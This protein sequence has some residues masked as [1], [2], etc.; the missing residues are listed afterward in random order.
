M[1]HL[2]ESEPLAAGLPAK[3]QRRS[4]L[5]RR[6]IVEETL[7]PGASVA[8]VAREHEVNANQVHYWRKL[9]QQ[10]LLD[11]NAS[12]AA[13][14]PVRLTDAVKTRSVL[15]APARR[16]LA[17]GCGAVQIELGRT[18]VRIEGPADAATLRVVLECLLG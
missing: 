15:P 14:V 4:K 12:S 2:A 1:D 17:P 9:Y 7:V 8:R 13:L 5:E 3:R 16:T 6:R 18:R 10:G 11:D